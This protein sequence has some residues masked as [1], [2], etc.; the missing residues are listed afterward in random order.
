[1]SREHAPAT[2]PAST[3]ARASKRPSTA[4]PRASEGLGVMT[5][6]GRENAGERRLPT[7]AGSQRR[8]ATAMSL[9]PA[10]PVRRRSRRSGSASKLMAAFPPAQEGF[11]PGEDLPCS[12]ALSPR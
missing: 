2:L 3:L 9:A 11:E 8:L 6:A 4:H 5:H 12:A 7:D 1:M 10:R